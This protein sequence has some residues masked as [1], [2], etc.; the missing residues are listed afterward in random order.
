MIIG[1]TNRSFRKIAAMIGTAAIA[2]TI[3]AYEANAQNAGPLTKVNVGYG[4]NSPQYSELFVAR[5]MSLFKKYGL[6]VELKL[7]NSSGQAPAVLNSGSVDI[8]GG[9]GAAFATGI[10]KGLKISWIGVSMPKWPLVMWAKK[11]INSLAELKGKKIGIT[12]PGSLGAYATN[13]VLA[14]GGLKPTDVD[15]V[16][17]G[18][19]AG[20][21][22][23]MREGR[24]DAI[25]INPPLGDQTA[26]GGT[27]AIYDAAQLQNASLTYA[28]MDNW[29]AK[30]ADTAAKFLAAVADAID[31][32]RSGQNKE[33]VKQVVGK[34][35]NINDGQLLDISYNYYS[36]L[37]DPTLAMS[38]DQFKDAF[39][40]AGDTSNPDVT[41]YFRI[42]AQK[43]AA[44]LRR[45]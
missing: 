27:H 5:D 30:N 24:V 33:Q 6:E 32:L 29:Y 37:L 10:S 22:A 9:G 41:K 44:E 14:A 45:K 43:K 13:V 17:L 36:K 12:G 38:V 23:G 40:Q 15:I 19:L 35:T 1:K 20:L 31:I 26:S 8:A 4:A 18:D 28:V 25:L 11:N 7:Y 3:A 21:L 42:D 16:S 34:A 39:K 2:V